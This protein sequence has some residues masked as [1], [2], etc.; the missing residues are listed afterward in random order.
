M[1]VSIGRRRAEE[2]SHH[3]RSAVR[4]STL[5]PAAASRIG[6]SLWSEGMEVDERVRARPRA[7][8]DLRQP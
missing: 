5:L 4:L 2:I 8:Y 6:W 7:L 3:A 1:G